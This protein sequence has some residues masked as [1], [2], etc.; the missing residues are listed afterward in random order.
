MAQKRKD[1][2]IVITDHVCLQ[3]EIKLE[4]P[5]KTEPEDNNAQASITWDGLAGG[6]MMQAGATAVAGEASSG[7]ENKALADH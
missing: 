2:D 4:D 7:Y 6:G 1:S 5:L 3:E